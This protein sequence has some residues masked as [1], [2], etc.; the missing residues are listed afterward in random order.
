MNQ[1]VRK[2]LDVRRLD[3]V[4]AV[5]LI[6]LLLKKRVGINLSERELDDVAFFDCLRLIDG[7]I[8]QKKQSTIKIAFQSF[9]TTPIQ[10]RTDPQ[11]SDI[12]VFRQ[13]LGWEE[14][15][16]VVQAFKHYFHAD[17]ATIIDAGGNIGL[18]SL[19]FSAHFP[20]AKIVTIEPDAGNFELL[21][22]NLS[23]QNA[24]CV[25][26]AIWS[27]NCYLKL[28]NDFRDKRSWSCRVEETQNETE[29]SIPA[30]SLMHLREQN[31]FDCID[32]LKMDIEGAEKEIFGSVNLDFL[33]YTKCI[34]IE[35]HDEFNCR[36]HIYQCLTDNGFTHFNK[37]ELTIG[38]NNKF[39]P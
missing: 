33:P 6:R 32:I 3:S 9:Y 22:T 24:T 1:Q 11:S 19:Y 8:I 29:N 30:Y 10:L 12:A 34:A 13:I 23:Q 27:R 5:Y 36:Q 38:I 25:Q 21:A 4:K 35:I 2:F 37:G 16:S 20:D 15:R 14:Y 26:G 18:T 28:V 7:F 31:K 17:A 39:L